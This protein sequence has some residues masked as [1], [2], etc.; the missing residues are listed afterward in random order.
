MEIT[1][2]SEKSKFIS[3]GTYNPQKRSFSKTA[4]VVAFTEEILN[5]KLY[6]LHS[7][8]NKFYKDHIAFKQSWLLMF[9]NFS[10][11]CYSKHPCFTTL[12]VIFAVFIKCRQSRSFHL[13]FIHGCHELKL[14]AQSLYC[15]RNL[16]AASCKYSGTRLEKRCLIWLKLCTPF[17]KVALV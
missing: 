10:Y 14:N 11:N 2:L 1:R 13:V 5:G 12:I 15:S 8:K 4:D 9:Q 17:L 16:K 6:F 3:Q 7:H